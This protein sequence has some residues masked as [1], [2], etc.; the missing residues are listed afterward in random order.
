[1]AIHLKLGNA[2]ALLEAQ[3]KARLEALGL[4]LNPDNSIN[5][6]SAKNIDGGIQAVRALAQDG[7][8]TPEAVSQLR[9]Q[10]LFGGITGR[11]LAP[12]EK[13]TNQWRAMGLELIGIAKALQ[14]VTYYLGADRT[15]NEEKLLAVATRTTQAMAGLQ[16]IKDAPGEELARVAP[17]AIRMVAD[18]GIAVADALANYIDASSLFR[19]GIL[20]QIVTEL[21]PRAEQLMVAQ[22]PKASLP[23]GPPS[24]RLASTFQTVNDTAEALVAVLRAMMGPQARSE[25][26][27]ASVTLAPIEIGL[28]GTVT[29]SVR[30]LLGTS[31]YYQ[32]ADE[33]KLGGPAGEVF[34]Q[35]I[36]HA[37]AEMKRQGLI[38]SSYGSTR[39]GTPEELKVWDEPPA[40]GS[41]KGISEPPV[42][43]A[44]VPASL[45]NDSLD[46][47]SRAVGQLVHELGTRADRGQ[48]SARARE[49]FEKDPALAPIA[50]TL[51]AAESAETAKN[52]TVVR[53]SYGV[54]LSPAYPIANQRPVRVSSSYGS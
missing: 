17:S 13:V 35:L 12:S 44:L 4:K 19:A 8:L 1:M 42:R 10:A 22:D 9:R 34:H 3:V 27:T 32:P 25:T 28:N 30:S 18:N 53:A 52:P 36:F 29:G 41:T 21:G 39:K 46:K 20:K 26:T 33:L 43:L 14:S 45:L 5:E 37:R 7:V 48:V 49:L 11:D 6:E 23:S 47:V 16:P 24:L 15:I 54:S 2:P 31:Y 40:L 38:A 50:T 51:Y